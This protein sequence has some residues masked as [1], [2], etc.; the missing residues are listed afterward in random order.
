[1]STVETGARAPV[2]RPRDEALTRRILAAARQELAAAG[3]EN[4]S[5]RQVAARANVTRK[6]VAARWPSADELLRAAVGV[7]DEVEFVASGD[8]AT[9]L[10]ELGTVF[11]SRLKSE[12]LDVQLR[13]T[14]DAIEHPEVYAE[15]QRRVEKPMSRALT[16]AFKAAQESGQM[17]PGDIT[18]FVRAF[19]G[20]LLA[21]AFGQPGR[22]APSS[23]DLDQLVAEVTK[24]AA[25]R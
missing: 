3:V 8:L 19:V 12:A 18:W 22:A 16:Q 6:A 20:A 21:T 11:I 1:M 9:D 15:L 4:F 2:G 10:T 14:A 17:R 25:V 13:V 24:W 23:D 5:V 7:I